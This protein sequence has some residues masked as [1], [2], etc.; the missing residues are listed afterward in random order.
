MRSRRGRGAVRPRARSTLRF[1]ALRAGDPVHRDTLAAELWPDLDRESALRGEQVAL[2][3]L[4]SLLDSHL[5]AA[6][7][8]HTGDV[9]PEEGTAEWVLA[10]RERVRLAVAAAEVARQEH[11]QI[12][13]EFGL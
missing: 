13:S 5:R 1:L 4:R 8:L 3:S 12:L 7:R 11:G 10:E 2:S 6:V 9:L